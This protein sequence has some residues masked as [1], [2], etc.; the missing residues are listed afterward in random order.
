M[1][2]KTL[3][4]LFLSTFMLSSCSDNDDNS[5]YGKNFTIKVE[6]DIA[7]FNTQTGEITFKAGELFE[8]SLSSKEK[9]KSGVGLSSKIT[10]NLNNT[11]IFESISIHPDYSNLVENDLVFVMK[12]DFKYYLLK[13]YPSLESLGESQTTSEQ[14]RSENIEKRKANWDKFINYLNSAGLLIE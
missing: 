5:K 6:N 3:I 11:S 14:I 12:D 1:K 13:G 8:A 7:E 9:L 4:A 2:I 10:F